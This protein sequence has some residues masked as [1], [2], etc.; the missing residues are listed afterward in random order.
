MASQVKGSHQLGRPHQPGQQI[1]GPLLPEDAQAHAPR[2]PEDDPW[3]DEILRRRGIDPEVPSQCCTE[4]CSRP[5]ET[6]VRRDNASRPRLG[7]EGEGARE[8][9]PL[10]PLTCEWGAAWP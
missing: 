5:R 7:E 9:N 2:S 6:W 4:G 3:P 8:T 10:A 1:G